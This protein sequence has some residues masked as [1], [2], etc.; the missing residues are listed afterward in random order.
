M[1]IHGVITLFTDN[2]ELQA[3]EGNNVI[4]DKFEISHTINDFEDYKLTSTIK[5][6]QYK[7]YDSKML[8]FMST[9]RANKIKYNIIPPPSEPMKPTG[10]YVLNLISILK[11]I[12]ITLIIVLII[13]LIIK[14]IKLNFKYTLNVSN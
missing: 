7:F 1:D 14:T 5:D 2:R 9:E 3:L 11:Y 6:K 4:N 12:L 10:G 13:I 8:P